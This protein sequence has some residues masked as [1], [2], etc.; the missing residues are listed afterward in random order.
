MKSTGNYN[1][2][3]RSNQSL[4][5]N[6]AEVYTNVSSE[7]NTVAGRAS[8]TVTFQTHSTRNGTTLSPSTK[9]PTFRGMR[10]T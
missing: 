2:P 8:T 4:R 7:N 9:I 1:T 5:N 6:D 10:K 3:K